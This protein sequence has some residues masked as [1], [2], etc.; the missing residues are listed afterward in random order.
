MGDRGAASY[1]A[2]SSSPGWDRAASSA[3]TAASRLAAASTPAASAA[4]SRAGTT[5]TGTT[6]KFVANTRQSTRP[7]A[8]PTGTPTAIPARAI[9]VACQQTDAAT[10]RRTNPS[11]FSSPVSRR[12]LAR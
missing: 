2:L 5:G 1:S 12:R 9:V 6:P 4:S 3:G 7:A 11:D 8:I 10:C